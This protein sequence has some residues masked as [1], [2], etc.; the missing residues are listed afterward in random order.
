[1]VGKPRGSHCADRVIAGYEICYNT[2]TKGMD[3]MEV[4]S[5]I[6][7]YRAEVLAKATYR[8]NLVELLHANEN[9]HTRILVKL[10]R[11]NHNDANFEFAQSFVRK[12]I[13][14]L[15]GLGV[16]MVWEQ[17]EY[18]DALIG[19]SGKYAI[20]IE[21]KINWAIDQDKQI[22]RYLEA[23]ERL[24]N[25]GSDKLYV[26]YLTDNGAK[27]PT[28]NSLTALAKEKLGIDGGENGRLIPLNY[29]D[30]IIPWMVEDVLPF[31][32]HGDVQTI[33]ALDQYIDYLKN[34][35]E[36]KP[37]FDANEERFFDSIFQPSNAAQTEYQQLKALKLELQNDALQKYSADLA[38][39]RT[40]LIELIERKQQ[41]LLRTNYLFDGSPAISQMVS[42][43]RGWA[44]S[45]G[46]CGPRTYQA[47][48][49]I[50][51]EVKFDNG[52]RM[53]F[54]LGVS[55]DRRINIGFFDNASIVVLKDGYPCLVELFKECFP[56]FY[57]RE[58]DGHGLW[59]G[60]VPINN[61][62]ELNEFLH[63]KADPFMRQFMKDIVKK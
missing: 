26:I 23:A 52:A 54:Q 5:L 13:P 48:T 6:K 3:I 12:H 56:E 45:I 42:C 17:I 16:P 21:N 63:Q 40:S 24:V 57:Y 4:K 19:V 7:K 43:V 10:L 34:R 2:N 39:D 28:E 55:S 32:R 30:D 33:T 60:T 53:K 1:V 58:D 50:V 25:V 49:I 27:K 35:L 31:C 61:E 37:E 8:M 51:S 22:E 9:A 62:D 36:D 38:V 14:D 20:I 41:S 15:D 47:T 11:Y 29:R 44:N 18:I 46:Y 59:S